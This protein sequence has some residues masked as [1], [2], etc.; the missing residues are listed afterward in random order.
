MFP[1]SVVA[2]IIAIVDDEESVRS[3][4]A[5]LIRAAGFDV[6]TFSSGAD[7][8]ASL[9]E[10]QPDCVLLDLRMPHMSGFDVQQGLSDAGMKLPVVL[11]SS[12]DAPTSKTRALEQGACAYLLKPFDSGIVL[13]AIEA[14]LRRDA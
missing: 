2:P 13:N 11:I 6:I 3:A 10:R 7:F 8:L 12:D 5:R 1:M 14:A 4:L 9:R